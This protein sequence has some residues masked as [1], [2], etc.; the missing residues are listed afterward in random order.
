MS[1]FTISTLG[2]F[3]FNLKLTI[4]WAPSA[5]PTRIRRSAQLGNHLACTPYCFL[6]K[7][8]MEVN[9]PRMITHD[10]YLENSPLI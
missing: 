3:K 1:V 7:N 8:R 5:R 6:G 9:S 10:N 4:H 2:L